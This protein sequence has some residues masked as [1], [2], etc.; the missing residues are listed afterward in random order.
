M[1]SDTALEQLLDVSTQ[2]REAVIADERSVVARGTLDTARADELADAGRRLLERAGA[3]RG[4][5]VVTQVDV[6]LD[7]GDVYVRRA[8]KLLAVATT[9]PAST[10]SL[11]AYDLRVALDRCGGGDA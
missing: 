1:D 6:S 4:G 5:L 11:V 7:G 3:L 2:V 10:R 8:G 9:V